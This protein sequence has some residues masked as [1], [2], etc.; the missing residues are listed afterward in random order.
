MTDSAN[1]VVAARKRLS[2][3]DTETLKDM[4]S[5]DGRTEWAEE[6]LRLELIERGANVQELDAVMMRRS[7]IAASA[8]PSARGTLWNYGVVGRILT[9]AGALL[10]FVMVH[11][12]HGPAA[13]TASGVVAVLG[14]YV[15]VLSRR[16]IAQGRHPLSGATSFVMYWQLGEAW[17]FLVVAVIVAIFTFAG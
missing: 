11:A 8:P 12:L 1:S 15:Y 9:M 2:D 10:W 17:L 14:I 16:T 5:A 13:L 4:W 7:E 6:A 3:I